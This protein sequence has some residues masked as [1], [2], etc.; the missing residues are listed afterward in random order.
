MVLSS[1]ECCSRMESGATRLRNFVAESD[2]WI[3]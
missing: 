3:R 1:Q 2:S